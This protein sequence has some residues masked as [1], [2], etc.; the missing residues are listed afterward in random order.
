MIDK[1]K[2]YAKDPLTHGLMRQYFVH[3]QSSVVRHP[4]RPA[5]GAETAAPFGNRVH[6]KGNTV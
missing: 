6:G 2:R 1:W 4:P 5:T 3:Q